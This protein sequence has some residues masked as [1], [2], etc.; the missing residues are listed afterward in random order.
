MDI[1]SFIEEYRK[2]NNILKEHVFIRYVPLGEKL[3]RANNII[4]AAYYIEVAGD[5]EEQK[6]RVLHIDSVVKMMLTDIS[7]VDMYTDIERGKDD[8]VLG[9]YDLLTSAGIIQKIKEM[10]WNQELDEFERIVDM[11]AKDTIAN[12]YE[13][14]SF[15]KSQVERFG[16]L[17][18]TALLPILSEIDTEKIVEMVKGGIGNGRE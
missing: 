10:I 7:F 9:E 15:V 1:K 16:N 14:H 13:P 12:E 6:R 17:V 4:D 8:T 5:S 11:V 18:G 3:T 2:N